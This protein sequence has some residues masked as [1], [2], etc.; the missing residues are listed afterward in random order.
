MTLHEEIKL[1]Y[2]SLEINRARL[3]KT[4]NPYSTYVYMDHS[5]YSVIIPVNDD[6]PL[7]FDEFVGFTIQTVEMYIEKTI[8]K[9]LMLKSKNLKNIEQFVIIASNFCDPGLNGRL[10]ENLLSNPIE[11]SSVWKQIFGNQNIKKE[12]YDI[13]GEL[14]VYDYLLESNKTIKW[15]ALEKGTHDF[16]TI[17]YSYEVKTTTN[18]YESFITINSQNQLVSNVP[19]GLF[20]VRVEKNPNGKNIDEIIDSLREKGIDIDIVN[21]YLDSNNLQKGKIERKEKYAILEKRMYIVDDQFPKISINEF[22]SLEFR[23]R[24]L[25]ISYTLDLSGIDYKIW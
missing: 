19:L 5:S 2:A 21:R 12:S 22:D 24:I 1:Y 13:F 8:N 16:E 17:G 23:S 7:Y 15:T 4:T 6:Y 11:W 18:K 10:R 20:F 9:V 25:K 3:L 14:L